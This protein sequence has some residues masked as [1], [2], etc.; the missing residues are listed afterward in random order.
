MASPIRISLN[1][2][3]QLAQRVCHKQVGED[4]WPVVQ[5]LVERYYWQQKNKW[6]KRLAQLEEQELTPPLPSP[7]GQA[8]E[9][10]VAPEARA[11]P[12]GHGKRSAADF[13]AATH[14]HHKFDD[15]H[16]G[17]HC[18]CC[19]K[20]R[21]YEEREGRIIRVVGQ[22]AFQVVVHHVQKVRCRLCGVTAEASYPRELL[23]AHISGFDYKACALL[24]VSHYL[25]GL[26]FK[27][28]ETIQ[29]WLHQKVAD[30][31][32][33]DVVNQVDDALLPVYRIHEQEQI[34][35][36][37]SVR[38]DDTGAKINN[39]LLND[40]KRSINAS[41]FYFEGEQGQ[42]VLVYT[43][44]HHAGEI[45]ASLLARRDSQRSLVRTV[46]GAS[47]NFICSDSIKLVDSVCN[48]HA[49]RRFKEQKENY[50]EEYHYVKNIY[51]Q[52]YEHDAYCKKHHLS[53]VAR[54]AYHQQYSAPLMTRLH[55]WLIE[56]IKSEKV[57]LGSKLSEALTYFSNQWKRLTE[58]LRTPGVPLDTNLV[59]QAV[60]V[61]IRYRANSR[62][63]QTELGAQVGDRMMS[64]GYSVVLAGLSP[65]DYFTWC[66]KHRHE[67]VSKAAE[68]TPA[69]FIR[70]KQQDNG[71]L[72]NT[73]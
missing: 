9:S 40:E 8:K 7:S 16:N 42:G 27:R 39:C 26:P 65:I 22:A 49:Y 1:E 56:K 59:E 19:E 29:A 50:P 66:L 70:L 12:P 64:L 44:A 10:A 15:F 11:K 55:N 60:K 63:Y 6:D 61:V 25:S 32:L 4:D 51:E 2:L 35:E 48:S 72:A 33:W 52:V 17:Q 23:A 43:G 37:V 30:A 36:A 57:E 62:S 41:V 20:G 34:N 18:P 54:L 45:F 13:L 68:F 31:C 47:K 3:S 53:P 14:T 24:V 73:S 71:Q 58:F 38:Y 67:L 5:E 21:M 28:L 46:D 69:A